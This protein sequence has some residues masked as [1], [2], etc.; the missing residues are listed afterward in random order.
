M[1]TPLDPATVGVPE[2]L[3]HLIEQQFERLAPTEQAIVEAASTIGGEFSAVAI[4]AGTGLRVED[5][6]ACCALL[7]RRRQFMTARGAALWPDGTVAGQ[8]RFRHTLYRDVVSARVPVGNR[9]RLHQQIARQL[10]VM[11]G[12][13]VPAMAAR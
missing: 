11:Y 12:A 2:T 9:I 1:P 4:A 5:V 7:A 6:D 8:Y 13:Q 10:D 3:H